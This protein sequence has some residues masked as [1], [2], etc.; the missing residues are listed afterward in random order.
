MCHSI[1]QSSMKENV[2]QGEELQRQSDYR[3]A[4]EELRREQQNSVLEQNEL[5]ARQ[6]QYTH[7]RLQRTHQFL[8][9]VKHKREQFLEALLKPAHSIQAVS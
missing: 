1:F 9:H 6:A 4:M 7:A 5:A 2:L 3:C 8:Q